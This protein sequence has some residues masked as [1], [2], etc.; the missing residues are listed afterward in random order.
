MNHQQPT[1]EQ[2]RQIAMQ[3]SHPT[4]DD[5]IRTAEQMHFSNIGMTRN[6]ISSLTLMPNDRVLELGH[7]NGKH[8]V[9]IL[10][11]AEDIS[12]QGLEISELMS[13]EARKVNTQANVS[14][15]LYEGENIPFEADCFNKILT[16]NTLYFWKNPLQLLNEI[17]R[18]LKPGGKFSFAFAQRDFME[19]LP[20][21]KFIFELYDIP[22]VEK[23]IRNSFFKNFEFKEFTEQITS[24]DG[25]SIERVYTIA[26]LMK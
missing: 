22:K 12:Y 2:F 20:F 5:G 6:T 24:K 7:G 23:L 21:T 18:V 10:D 4:G 3:L 9:E 1:E 25:Q 11:K 17:Y 19:K 8:I 14:F 16:V 26:T 15:T 13:L